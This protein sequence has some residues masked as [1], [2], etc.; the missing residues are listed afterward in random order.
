MF[1]VEGVLQRL[2]LFNSTMFVFSHSL[3]KDVLWDK[4]TN[5]LCCGDK[6]RKLE[7]K[8]KKTFVSRRRQ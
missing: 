6:V 7:I 3:H 8:A 2:V 4:V 1:G 5:R